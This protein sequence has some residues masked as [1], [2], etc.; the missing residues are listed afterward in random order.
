MLMTGND[1]CLLDTSVIV[2]ALKKNAIVGRKLD[3]LKQIYVPLTAVGELL[4]G[5]YKSPRLVY[6]LQET[7]I[8]LAKCIILF[9]D[10][11]TADIYG[12][13]KNNLMKKGKSIPENDIWIAAIALQHN[14]FLYKNDKHFREVEGLQ[15]FNP[16][17]S[18]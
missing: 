13:A 16:L 14:L 17:S 11:Q 18:I 8:F 1:K 15:L 10:R 6:H 12:R 9:P 2:L 7:E 4:Y 5:A 3:A